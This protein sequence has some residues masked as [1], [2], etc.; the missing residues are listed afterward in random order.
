MKRKGRG[1]GARKGKGKGEG[2]KGEGKGRGSAVYPEGEEGK[3]DREGKQDGWVL[4]G[5][6]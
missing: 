1:R 4:R 5:M 6:T 3:K 2:R